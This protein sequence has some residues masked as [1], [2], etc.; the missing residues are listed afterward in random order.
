MNFSW[1]LFFIAWIKVHRWRLNPLF[2]IRWKGT[3]NF[4][5]NLLSLVF[6]EFYSSL[7][8]TC[9]WMTK[10]N[11]GSSKMRE[12]IS[13]VVVQRWSK[14]ESNGFLWNYAN[15]GLLPTSFCLLSAKV[16]PVSLRFEITVEKCSVYFLWQ[17]NLTCVGLLVFFLRKLVEKRSARYLNDIGFSISVFKRGL[18]CYK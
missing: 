17:S 16:F 8:T 18:D 6:Y 15:T 2:I 14:I 12:E 1:F 7:N 10:F 3:S 5:S 9:N 13:L 11:L 4:S